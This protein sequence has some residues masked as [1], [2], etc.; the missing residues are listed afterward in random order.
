MAASAPTI[1]EVLEGRAS[2]DDLDGQSQALLRA[3]WAE[4][5]GANI[6]GLD[7][8]SEFASEGRSFAYLDDDGG[9]VVRRVARPG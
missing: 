1:T 6:S 7:L 5:T 4:Q 9:F 8:A 2:Y 3:K